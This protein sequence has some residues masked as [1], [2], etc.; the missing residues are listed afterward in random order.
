MKCK[1]CNHKYSADIGQGAP[2]GSSSP[3]YF[4]IFDILL[5][6]ITVFLFIKLGNSLWAWSFFGISAYVLFETFNAK[7][8]CSGSEGFSGGE[9]CPECK[10]KNRV[11][12]WSL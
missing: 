12:P 5:W 1:H 8:S 11:Y 4:F 6:L 9:K 10:G 2:G 7:A 3:G